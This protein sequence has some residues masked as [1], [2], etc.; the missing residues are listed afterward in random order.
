MSSWSIPIPAAPTPCLVLVSN[1]SAQA[2][3]D[4]VKEFFLFC[5]KIS[6]FQLDA[7][8]HQALIWFDKE[9]AAKTATM[10]SN[11]VIAD[12]QIQVHYYF[13]QF[14][15]PTDKDDASAAQDQ[16]NAAQGSQEAKPKTGIVTE[17]VA[18]GFTL[19]DTILNRAKSFDAKYGVVAY[20]QPYYQ[21]ALEKAQE[22]EGKYGLVRTV[23]ERAQQ[24]DATYHV[25][26][27]VLDYAHKIAA[28][29][30]GQVAQGVYQQAVSTVEQGKS[31]ADEKKAHN[32]VAASQ[33]AAASST[34]A[35]TS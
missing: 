18:A 31:L 3:E 35:S 12:A 14:N 28:S 4:K 26:D 2:T 29:G 33:A 11:A 19:S 8:S 17:L 22:L 34:P 5:G 9:S 10:L 6:H 1:I 20:M 23:T 32:V 30:P 25:K 7:T 13:D 21:Q 16:S 27:T 24:V 15:P